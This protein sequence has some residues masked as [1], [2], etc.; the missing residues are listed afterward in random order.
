[1]RLPAIPKT[2]KPLEA[3]I[4]V[5]LREQSG[6]TIERSVRLTVDT[7]TARVGIKPLFASAQVG[8]GETARFETVLVNAEGAP[9]SGAHR[10]TVG[11]RATPRRADDYVRRTRTETTT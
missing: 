4:I 9:R 3:E 11:F 10:Q 2:A 5:R 8:E 7:R 6:R 1:M